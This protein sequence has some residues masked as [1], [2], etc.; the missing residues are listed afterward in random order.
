[1]IEQRSQSNKEQ[2]KPTLYRVAITTP[3]LSEGLE[4][5]TDPSKALENILLYD[6]NPNNLHG[7]RILDTNNKNKVLLWSPGYEGQYRYDVHAQ[8]LQCSDLVI[9]GSTEPGEDEVLSYKGSGLLV[10]RFSIFYGSPSRYS[11][12]TPEEGGYSLDIPKSVSKVK[13]MLSNDQV[14]EALASRQEARIR[15][16]ISDL[17]KASNNGSPIL[18]T[19]YLS[20]ALK[21]QVRNG[22]RR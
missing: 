10:A 12:R 17:N 8:D 3:H 9:A 7:V 19:P 16:A 15:N 1:M 11:L 14:L 5:F 4:Q 20:Q 22:G 21:I 2:T 6:Y 13:A 18:I